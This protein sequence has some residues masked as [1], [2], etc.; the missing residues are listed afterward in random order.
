MNERLNILEWITFRRN[1]LY[2]MH[3][4]HMQF[5]QLAEILQISHTLD[6]L[7]PKARVKSFAIV[8]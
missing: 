5:K 6:L 4:Y 8:Y 3:D 7:F 1:A 2:R